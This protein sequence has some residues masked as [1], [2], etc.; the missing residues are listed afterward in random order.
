MHMPLNV[1]R[2]PVRKSGPVDTRTCKKISRRLDWFAL[3]PL[4]S[5]RSHPALCVPLTIR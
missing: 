4:S 3:P 2:E 5:E 1:T